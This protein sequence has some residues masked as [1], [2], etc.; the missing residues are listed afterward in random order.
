DVKITVILGCY[1]GTANSPRAQQAQQRLFLEIEPDIPG[2][3]DPQM[4]GPEIVDGSPIEILLDNRR[5][6]VGCTR[7]R[8]GVSELLAD[9]S[10][11]RRDC[12]LLFGL[13]LGGLT[14][15]EGDRR[16]QRPA[17]GAEV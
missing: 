13:R 10:H 9:D 15:R 16:Q 8:R 5:A 4:P 2:A 1:T 12:A 17:P 6:D 14:L 7:N 11:H 3:D